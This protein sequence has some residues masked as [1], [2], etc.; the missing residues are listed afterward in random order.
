MTSTSLKSNIT[1]SNSPTSVQL[2]SMCQKVCSRWELFTIGHT[3]AM[4]LM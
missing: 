1:N 2:E 3:M 4:F